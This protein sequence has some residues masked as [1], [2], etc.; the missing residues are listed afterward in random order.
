MPQC[1]ERSHLQIIREVVKQGTLTAAADALCLSQSALSHAM[2]KLE[3]RVGVPLWQKQGRH[4]QLTDA[5]KHLLELSNQVLPLMEKAELQL[6]AWSKGDLGQLRIG[7]ECYPCYHWLQR[8]LVP[9][10]NRW[11]NLNVDIKQRF[12]F[13]AVEALKR[14][15]VDVVITP[16]P[17]KSS[18]LVFWPVNEYEQV[19][20][21]HT[22][23][24]FV[25]RTYIDPEDLATET[26]ITYPLEPDRL[27]VFHRFLL[28][29]D[30]QPQAHMEIEN[31]DFL[32]ELVAQGRGVAALPKWLVGY[33]KDKLPLATI[34]LGEQG[35]HK[36]LCLGV[37]V[38][39]QSLPY[40]SHLV[41]LASEVPA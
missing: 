33:Y 32:L 13:C 1:L 29:A 8:F 10:M 37:R 31:T 22:S 34:S 25:E 11:P 5:G 35:I 41:Q 2:T 3:D 36:E 27:D 28:P 40:L 19:L 20:V 7:V 15:E 17:P 23:H 6:E 16:D 39:D 18:Q 24:R 4:L 26:L 21:T 14:H 9:F 38:E 12:Q 30:R